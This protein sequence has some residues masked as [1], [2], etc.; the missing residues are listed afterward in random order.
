M[1]GFAK[2]VEAER[3]D[4]VFDIGPRM[5]GTAAGEGAEL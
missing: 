5:L 2:C 3:L 1:Q 4:V